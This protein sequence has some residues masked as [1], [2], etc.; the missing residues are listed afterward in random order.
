MFF[1]LG[2]SSFIENVCF[3]YIRR[4]VQHVCVCVVVYSMSGMLLVCWALGINTVGHGGKGY[5][6]KARQGSEGSDN[7]PRRASESSAAAGLRWRL[8]SLAPVQ[9]YRLGELVVQ[10]H[11]GLLKSD[12]AVEWEPVSAETA[13]TE[14]D[15]EKCLRTLKR[16]RLKLPH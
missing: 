10:L 9:L 14:T 8:G 2:D 3:V 11:F 1:G 7:P 16:Q 6:D 15:A 4:W 5:I 12:N 13:S